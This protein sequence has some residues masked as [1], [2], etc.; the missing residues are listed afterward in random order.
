LL[1]AVVFDAIAV[2]VV[3]DAVTFAVIVFAVVVVIN[4]VFYSLLL[5]LLSLL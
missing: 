4:G 2:V 5:M 1:Y 3:A